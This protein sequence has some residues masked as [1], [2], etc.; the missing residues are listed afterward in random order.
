MTLNFTEPHFHG[1]SNEGREE[2]IEIEDFQQHLVL[3]F[4][5]SN[6]E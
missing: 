1:L 2:N 6:Q 5:N 3:K 4:Y